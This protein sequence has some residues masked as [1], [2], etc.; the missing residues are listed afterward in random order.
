MVT[1]APVARFRKNG[2]ARFGEP[3]VVVFDERDEESA[4][5][6]Q[7]RV[8]VADDHGFLVFDDRLD[9]LFDPL[10]AHRPAKAQG[11]IA[12]VQL[13]QMRA[14]VGVLR[15][16]QQSHRMEGGHPPKSSDLVARQQ[17]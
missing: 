12:L 15:R 7:R 4:V 3:S 8:V 13:L 9:E 17:P 10:V 16:L 5:Q 11:A 14:I 2:E 6:T 1:D